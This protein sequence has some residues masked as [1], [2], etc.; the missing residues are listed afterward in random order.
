[1]PTDQTTFTTRARK[2]EGIDKTVRR[3]IAGAALR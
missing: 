2:A 3:R 1:M